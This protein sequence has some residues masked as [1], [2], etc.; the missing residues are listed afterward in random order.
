MMQFER[1]KF[2]DVPERLFH[3]TKSDAAWN[4][5]TGGPVGQLCF[6]LKDAKCK[7]DKSE[8]M[9]G[10]SLLEG[11]RSYLTNKGQS[12]ILDQLQCF[13][14]VY[15]NS[16]TETGDPGYM[17]KTYGN[18]RLEFDFSRVRLEV[19]LRE[20]D[21]VISPDIHELIMLYCQD[22]EMTN[23]KRNQMRE[24]IG[25]LIDYL[26]LE[27]GLIQS[28]PLIKDVEVWGQEREWRQVF[29][30]QPNDEFVSLFQEEPLRLK[31]TYPL[32]SL[33]GITIFA[34]KQQKKST[35]QYYYKF[36]SWLMRNG[37]QTQIR[38]KYQW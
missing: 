27:M 3:Y 38:I 8:L 14:N 26:K 25:S 30:S 6:L 11:I 28:I 15:L 1:S 7:N 12:S 4:I 10:V 23:D 21:Y 36:K 13:D 37:L 34:D 33:I 31:K 9:L 35:L 16:F 20:C 24:N 19:P 2:R 5:V 17:I 29:Y 22:L 32:H 18:V